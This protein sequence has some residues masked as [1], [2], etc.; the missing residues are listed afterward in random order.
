MQGTPRISLPGLLQ[1][2][3]NTARASKDRTG[4]KILQGCQEV[5]LKMMASGICGAV[6]CISK[7]EPSAEWNIIMLFVLHQTGTCHDHDMF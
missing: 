1:E 2:W 4:C 3:E 7:C 6:T 5:E